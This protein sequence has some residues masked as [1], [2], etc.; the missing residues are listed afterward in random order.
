MMRALMV[1]G[2]GV[3]GWTRK[4]CHIGRTE[5]VCEFH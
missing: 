3:W 1:W 5:D 4:Q 2:E